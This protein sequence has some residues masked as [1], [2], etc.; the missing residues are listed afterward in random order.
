MKITNPKLFWNT[1]KIILVGTGNVLSPHK[2]FQFER[3]LKNVV[4]NSESVFWVTFWKAT[5]LGFVPKD[6]GDDMDGWEPLFGGGPTWGGQ[7]RVLLLSPHYAL[8][9]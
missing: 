9:V 8:Y 3:M 2:Y 6:L 1:V 4:V 7:P 5:F